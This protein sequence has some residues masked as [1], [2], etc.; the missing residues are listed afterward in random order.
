MT[1]DQRHVDAQMFALSQARQKSL[2]WRSSRF[3]IQK[4]NKKNLIDSWWVILTWARPLPSFP[5]GE[6]WRKQI[7]ERVAFNWR[8]N[9]LLLLYLWSSWYSRRT[10]NNFFGPGLNH[11]RPCNFIINNFVEWLR[12]SAHEKKSETRGEKEKFLARMKE[13]RIKQSINLLYNYNLHTC[14]NTSSCLEWKTTGKLKGTSREISQ[15]SLLL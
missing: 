4:E 15:P 8:R 10:Q 6:E 11:Q 7:S 14:N 5:S 13:N 3:L 9:N 1:R 12:D 2:R